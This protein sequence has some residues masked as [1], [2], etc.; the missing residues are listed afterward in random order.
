MSFEILNIRPEIVRALKEEGIESPTEIQ[1]KTMPL[2]KQGKDVIGISKTGSGKTIAFAVPMIEM[3]KPKAGIQVIVLAP[4][5]ELAVQISG[6]FAKFSKYL[7]L[8]IATVF[9]GVSI[10]PQMDAIS[11]AE[12][13][14]GTP[15]RTLDH[16]RRGTLD[17]SKIR[18]A[19]I[20][21]ADKMVDMGFI[22]DINQILSQTPRRK[23]VL[24]FGATVGDEVEHLREE[25]MTR[26]V[27]V[28]TESQVTQDLLKQ[29]YY[30]ISP[31]KKFSLLVHLLRKGDM[32][33]TIIFCSARTTV[34]L[35]N[36]NMRKQGFNVAMIHGKLSQDRRLK[37]MERFNKGEPLILVASAVAARGLH[38]AEVTHIINY[39]LSQDPE[40]Y[41]HRI[42]RTARAGESGRAITLL[43]E[44]DH[45]T[46]N[47]IFRRFDLD[48]E[49]LPDEQFKRMPFDASGPREEQRGSYSRRP[50]QY[51]RGGPRRSGPPRRTSQYGRTG[52]SSRTGYSAGGR[53]QHPHRRGPWHR[54]RRAGY[55]V[56]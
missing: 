11:R 4:T 36:R 31:H 8:R 14:V 47:Q 39:D 10:Q 46:F 56:S 54:D 52:S 32:G 41:I 34:E 27:V 3:I 45:N 9:G 48:V 40:E 43:S 15:G 18:C 50:G 21:E 55:S 23:Q 2:I 6:E 22:E 20:D 42:G 49:E 25:H 24:L 29:F 44:R 7:R 30:N 13:F 16:L 38:I 12:I 37:V 35:L 53:A 19:I 5:R 26:P 51:S 28:Q 1:I 33:R 17:L